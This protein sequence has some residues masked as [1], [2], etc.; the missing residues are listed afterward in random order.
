MGRVRVL[1]AIILALAASG[2]PAEPDSA[3]GAEPDPG[4]IESEARALMESG[5]FGGAE[6]RYERLTELVP[7]S[8]VPHYNLACALAR[9]GDGDDAAEAL[10]RAVALGFTDRLALT[11][12]PDLAS[13]RGSS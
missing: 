8:F 7:E 11:T 13:I 12:D 10:S 2:A 5:D 1:I 3:P 9:Q 4:A 6:R